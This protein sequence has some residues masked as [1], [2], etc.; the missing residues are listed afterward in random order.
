MSLS[1]HWIALLLCGLLCN[2]AQ[3]GRSSV[4][5]ASDVAETGDCEAE[6]SFE[7]IRPR[8][9][10][11]QRETSLRLACGIGWDTEVEATL[12]R[13]RGG[14]AGSQTLVLEAKTVLAERGER[15]IGWAMVLAVGAE[16]PDGGSWRQTEHS[17]TLEATYSLGATWLVEAKLGAARER[18]DRRDGLRWAAAV[19]HALSERIEVRAEIEGDDRGRPL[20]GLALKV[21][22]WPEDLKLKLGYGS[23]SGPQAERRASLSLQVEF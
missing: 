3:A 18:L 8:G 20:A 1:R 11:R 22:L 16:K 15:R 9:E 6:M 23:R 21:A 17:L 19:E 7:R 12:A 10:A 14:D 4:A 2:A 13:Q 5:D